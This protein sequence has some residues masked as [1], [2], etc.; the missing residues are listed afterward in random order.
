M[1]DGYLTDILPGDDWPTRQIK[2]QRWM[3]AMAESIAGVYGTIIPLTGG[4]LIDLQ[5][6]DTRQTINC[7][8]VA[9]VKNAANQI[10]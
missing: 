3:K 9:W 8:H 5:P 7:T 1:A 4:Y 6:A 2:T 10:P